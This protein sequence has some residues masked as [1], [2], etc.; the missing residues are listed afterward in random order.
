[1]FPS[2]NWLRLVFPRHTAET[3]QYIG[4]KGKR[5]PHVLK[6][7][8]KHNE[9]WIQIQA[10]SESSVFLC[11]ICH[12]CAESF[13][14]TELPQ[15]FGECLYQVTL[16]MMDSLRSEFGAGMQRS[17]PRWEGGQRVKVGDQVSRRDTC[18]GLMG[19]AVAGG[20]PLDPTPRCWVPRVDRRSLCNVR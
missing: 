13:I 18:E 19:T 2:L 12:T 6:E 8:A 16:R 20:I 14:T 3:T 4:D 9:T 17:R 1:M 7:A 5:F 11:F 10:V 15:L